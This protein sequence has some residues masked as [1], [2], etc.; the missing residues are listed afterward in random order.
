MANLPVIS[1]KECVNA[2]L[3]LGYRQARQRGSHVR[4]VCEGL[5]S[6][7]VPLH[8]TLD[9]G[10]LRSILRAIDLSVEDFVDLLH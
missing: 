10:T 8:D 6:V 3:K 4:L 5:K 1:G 9:R 2:L 7:T